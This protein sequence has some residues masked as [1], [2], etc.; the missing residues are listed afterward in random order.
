M[1]FRFFLND[2]DNRAKSVINDAIARRKEDEIWELAEHG[3]V[4]VEKAKDMVVEDFLHRH[5]FGFMVEL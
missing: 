5:N 3:G 1:R 4:E 2:L